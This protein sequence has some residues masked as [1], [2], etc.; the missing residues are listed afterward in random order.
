MIPRRAAGWACLAAAL[1]SGE[2]AANG[3]ARLL[4]EAG[5]SLSM[6]VK[7]IKEMRLREAF[8]TTLRQQ[9]DFSCG[10]AAVATL[11]THHYGVPVSEETVFRAMYDAG[12]PARIQREGFSLLDIKRYLE[13]RGFEADGFEA[14]LDQLGEA[15]IPA[16][17]LVRERGYNHFVVIKGLANGKVLFS[18]PAVG[19][20]ILPRR[21]F[22]TIWFGGILF[23]IRSH[24][25]A[26]RFNVAG[27]W[28]VRRPAPMADGI[29]R[30]GLGTMMLMLPGS[31]DF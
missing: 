31:N 26:A 7:T 30:S 21:E 11:L 10:S 8:R 1:A 17:V 9:Y 5:S 14:S 3:T 6:S 27:D 18:D 23:A 29:D 2:V 22:E 13:S 24:R 19:T 28:I 4:G 16:I 12:E 25:D 20:R 15:R